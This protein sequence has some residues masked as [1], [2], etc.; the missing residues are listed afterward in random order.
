MGT[1]SVFTNWRDY[2]IMFHVSSMLPDLKSDAK[3][4]EKKKHLGNDIVL[5]VFKEFG[6]QYNPKTLVSQFNHVILVVEPISGQ[7]NEP[8]YRISCATK[9]EVPEYGPKITEL[10]YAHDQYFRD[11]VLAKLVNGERAAYYAPDFHRRL[12]RTRQGILEQCAELEEKKSKSGFFSGK[13]SVSGQD[14][15]ERAKVS[16]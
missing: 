2:D 9:E 1:H 13:I 6:C 10:V 15:A 16:K 7:Y 11:F 4:L 14:S 12:L 5:L 3:K 8:F